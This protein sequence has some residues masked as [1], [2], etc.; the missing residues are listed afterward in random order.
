MP[1]KLVILTGNH[2]VGKTTL[3]NQASN[4]GYITFDEELRA[5]IDS[6]GPLE[7]QR[8][9]INAKLSQWTNVTKTIFSDDNDN[10]KYMLDRCAIDI[11]VYSM[12][13][14]LYEDCS[15]K[16]LIE[17]EIDKTIALRECGVDIEFYLFLVN[18]LNRNWIFND[19]YRIDKELSKYW[20]VELRNIINN[21][22]VND[23]SKKLEKYFTVRLI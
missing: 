19:D 13:F 1:K 14:G 12:A 20:T 7:R 15:F 6:P 10:G 4:D 23:V 11:L 3:L 8:L 9:M 22:Y 21:I 17:S 16:L 18:D 2:G 5:Y